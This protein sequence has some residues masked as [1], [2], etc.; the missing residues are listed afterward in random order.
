[1]RRRPL[2]S[3]SPPTNLTL[4]S[5]PPVDYGQVTRTTFVRSLPAGTPRRAGVLTI[6][7]ICSPD[8][9]V[10]LLSGAAPFTWV[11]KSEAPKFLQVLPA[12]SHSTWPRTRSR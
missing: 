1:M 10:Q 9:G 2:T 8:F 3:W 7:P 5:P 12:R 4:P 11:L 6:S